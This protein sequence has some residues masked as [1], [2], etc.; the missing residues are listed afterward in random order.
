MGPPGRFH[1]LASHPGHPG[2]PIG[3]QDGALAPPRGEKPQLQE[4]CVGTF[5]L[6]PPEEFT[7]LWRKFSVA[8]HRRESRGTR[9]QA[10]TWLMC[11]LVICH[12]AERGPRGLDKQD[13]STPTSDGTP[14]LP[15]WRPSCPQGHTTAGQLLSQDGP[16]EAT[17]SD[18]C[19]QTCGTSHSYKQ[20]R[21]K[22]DRA[23]KE[24]RAGP[25][26]LSQKLSKILSHT[27]QNMKIYFLTGLE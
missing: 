22:R 23:E 7:Q 27:M 19:A 10:T 13:K 21:A 15:S 25:E 2:E 6:A 8:K 14:V 26:G 9:A 16:S 3:G 1:P 5:S 17:V 4:Q 24:G 18:T 12:K 11:P 20:L